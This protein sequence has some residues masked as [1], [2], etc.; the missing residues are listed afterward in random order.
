MRLVRGL[1]G[2][3]AG[4]TVVGMLVVVGTAVLADRRG[5]PGP[6]GESVAW[7]VAVAAV[8]L[9]AQ[10]YS[11]RHRGPAAFTGSMVVFLAAGLLLW[12]QWWS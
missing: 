6:G 8:A 9:A 11:D 2:V 10:I 7:H 3:V 1:S 5:F 4:G 12:T